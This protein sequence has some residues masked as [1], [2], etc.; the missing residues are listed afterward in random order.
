[1]IEANT[2]VSIARSWAGVPFRH[3]GRSRQGVDCIGFV[4]GVMQEAGIKLP[5]LPPATYTRRVNDGQ[6]LE[7]ILRHCVP[8]K[9][10]KPGALILVR[11]PRMQF[12]THVALCLGDT[13]M[14][15]HLSAGSVLEVG[16]RAQ[17]QRWTH[18]IYEL[19]GVRYS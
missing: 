3:Q 11:W 9:E 17:W 18:G 15:A 8:I 19:P 1:M 4:L 2:L 14:H 10:A 6:M 16:Y 13:M 7:H 12:P 5:K